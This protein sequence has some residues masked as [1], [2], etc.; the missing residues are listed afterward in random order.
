[1]PALTEAPN[2]G[3]GIYIHWPFCAAKCPYCD[4]N[5]HVRQG[6]DQA[7]W[8]AALMAEL[9]WTHQR[10]P[11]GPATSIFFGGGTP[12]LMDPATVG[13][14]ID[15]IGALWG[16]TDDIEITLEANPTSVEAAKLKDFKAA[17]VGRVSVGLQALND[18]DLKALGR[19]HSASEGIAAYR[20]AREVFERA[21]FDLIYARMGQ[22]P[23]QWEAELREALAIGPDHVSLYQLTLE[24]GTPFFE[25]HKR[26]TLSVPGEDDAAE[27]YEITQRLCE[28]ANLPAY[29]VSNHARADAACRHNLT[30]WRLEDYAGI[31]PGAHGRLTVDG[32][33]YA[34]E[35]VLGPEDWL[36][37]V[38]ARRHGTK[39]WQDLAPQETGEEYLMMALRL[40]E[41]ASL[42]RYELLSGQRFDLGK[43]ASLME[44]GF[45][46][47]VGDVLR[48]TARGRP[49]LNHLTQ[50]LLT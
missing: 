11:D 47:Q 14:L 28:A 41:G 9:E 13:A 44:A 1:M 19:L 22:T 16:C 25:M 38:E 7:R 6:I 43:A 32:I 27:M 20:T 33:R 34:T 8:R 15:R 31:G 30:Y 50:E 10:R 2:Q 17:G 3:F 46:E 40:S 39:V 48:A 12:S 45:L 49:V 4:F 18:K 21:S 29:E 35:T 5:S 24:E 42:A 36:G 37:L 23:K 26:G